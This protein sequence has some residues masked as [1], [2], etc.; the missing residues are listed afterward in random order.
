MLKK[1]KKLA[2]KYITKL[3]K[4]Q[5]LSRCLGKSIFYFKNQSLSKRKIKLIKAQ[6]IHR[7]ARLGQLIQEFTLMI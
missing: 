4:A 2:R 7:Q 6:V 3:Q 5:Y 1:K